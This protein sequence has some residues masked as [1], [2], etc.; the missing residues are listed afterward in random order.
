MKN[1]PI[2]KTHLNVEKTIFDNQYAGFWQRLAANIIDHLIMGLIQLILTLMLVILFGVLGIIS[3]QLTLSIDGL[4]ILFISGFLYLAISRLLLWWL[5]YAYCESKYG[6][7]VGKDIIG[8]KV[9]DLAGNPISFKKASG[10]FLGRLISFV[11]T[12]WIGYLIAPFTNKKQAL[13]DMISSCLVLKNYP[14]TPTNRP[15]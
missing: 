11:G 6:A 14:T 9:T 15:S 4:I 13:H 8:L 10:R 3:L 12:L 1:P 5:Y 2:L 7:T